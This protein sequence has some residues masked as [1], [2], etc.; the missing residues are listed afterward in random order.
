MSSLRSRVLPA[1]RTC[2][3]QRKKRPFCKACS[4]A[5]GP[6]NCDGGGGGGGGGV[7]L[8]A[9]LNVNS[10]MSGYWKRVLASAW[11]PQVYGPDDPDAAQMGKNPGRLFSRKLVALMQMS[12]NAC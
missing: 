9:K 7:G 8:G 3:T 10:C 4:G 11:T 5:A 6:T 12:K 1:F 2:L